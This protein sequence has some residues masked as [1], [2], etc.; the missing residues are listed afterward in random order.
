MPNREW[1]GNAVGTSNILVKEVAAALPTL[2]SV[3]VRLALLY[4]FFWYLL[5]F[6]IELWQD[7]LRFAIWVILAAFLVV[8]LLVW[9]LINAW[10]KFDL[11]KNLPSATLFPFV[12]L[13]LIPIAAV[14]VATCYARYFGWGL[15]QFTQHTLKRIAGVL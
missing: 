15:L 11:D 14:A 13:N 4:L 9:K 12:L 7:Y 1:R 6:V 8:G 3:L 10:T 5:D 2:V